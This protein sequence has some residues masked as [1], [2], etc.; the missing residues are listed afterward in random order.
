M[1][2]KVLIG[3]ALLVVVLAVLVSMQPA[4]YRVSRT[5]TI[6]APS[7]VVFDQVNDFHKWEG[8]SPW[9]KL[10]PAMKQTYEGPASGV[11]A[12]YD[13]S[14]NNDV[15]QGRMTI[16]ES[17]PGDLVRIKLEFLKPFASVS[18]T[19]FSFKPEGNQTA[20][21]WS[22]AGENNLMSKV[23]QVFVSMDK[24]VGGDFEKGLTAMKTVSEAAA[25]A[26]VPAKK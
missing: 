3:V 17:R 21:V 4:S 16:S 18:D 5:I 2:K 9:A 23:M 7:S 13:W 15:G 19:E 26:P 12:K 22:M 8:W 6:S 25:A 1:L 20:V 10:D 24:M 11:G 14:G